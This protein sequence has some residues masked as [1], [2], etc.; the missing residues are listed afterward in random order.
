MLGLA[1]DDV[2]RLL[3]AARYLLDHYLSKDSAQPQEGVI[4]PDEDLEETE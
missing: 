4:I 2:M 1:N 3:S